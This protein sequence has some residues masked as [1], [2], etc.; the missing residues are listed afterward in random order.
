VA[1]GDL[2]RW[3]L[4][5]TPRATC[6]SCG[7]RVFAEPPGMGMRGV[8]AL[9]LPRGAF[10]PQFHIQCQHALLPVKDGLPHFKSFPPAFGGPDERVEW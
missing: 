7:T 5:S 3:Q 10:R 8:M 6:P 4:R 1:G 2:L 9:L